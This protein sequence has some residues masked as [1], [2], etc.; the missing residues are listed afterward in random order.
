MKNYQS[1]T[2]IVALKIIPLW[3]STKLNDFCYFRTS[4][5]NPNAHIV[6]WWT[7]SC[8]NF[9]DKFHNPDIMVNESLLT[10]TFWG[11]IKINWMNE[12]MNTWM[13][14]FLLQMVQNVFSI[15]L[16]NIILK[17]VNYWIS[18]KATGYWQTLAALK[19]ICWNQCWFLL[20]MTI[21]LKIYLYWW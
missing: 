7:L 16:I 2:L 11:K 19:Y 8:T 4:V 3:E 18:A 17:F 1:R 21:F 12:R 15:N 14:T 20:V 5:N 9:D 6:Q 13:M 10:I